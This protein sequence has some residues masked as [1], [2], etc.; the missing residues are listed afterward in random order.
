MKGDG[1]T[2]PLLLIVMVVLAG[3]L[4]ISAF[5]NQTSDTEAGLNNSSGNTSDIVGNASCERK[6]KVDY[7]N[8]GPGYI[9]CLDN[10][11]CG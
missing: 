7:P 5:F 4:L 1:G 9:Q 8:E 3:F 10:N 2:K 6:C 11:G